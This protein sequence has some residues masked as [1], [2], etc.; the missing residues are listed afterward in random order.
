ML[1][2]ND[3]FFGR[4]FGALSSEISATLVGSKETFGHKGWKEGQFACMEYCIIHEM[5]LPFSFT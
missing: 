5:T 4:N 3:I 2:N 1:N